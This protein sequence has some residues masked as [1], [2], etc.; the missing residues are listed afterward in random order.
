[1]ADVP[2]APAVA[3]PRSIGGRL[4]S[5]PGQL[6]R[7]QTDESM[8]EVALAI[9]QCYRRR[10]RGSG[11]GSMTAATGRCQTCLSL[12]SLL[13]C[14]ADIG[15]MAIK[16]RSNLRGEIALL[17]YSFPN[18]SI[19]GIYHTPQSA[20]RSNISA[21]SPD[22]LLRSSVNPSTLH[23]GNHKLLTYEKEGTEGIAMRA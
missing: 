14:P 4:N 13:Q 16:K 20:L 12:V 21:E 17:Q 9:V 8:I 23:A 7:R 19:A 3:C 18:E 22:F 10:I 11:T 2:G 5:A 6:H 1:M 15:W